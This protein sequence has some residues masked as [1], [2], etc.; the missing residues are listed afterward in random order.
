MC[1]DFR[2]RA[3]ELDRTVRRFSIGAKKG[4]L[5]VEGDAAPLGTW[6]YPLAG[7]WGFAM[8][9]VF[10]Q[11]IRLCYRVEARSEGLKNRSGV[12]RNAMVFHVL[13]NRGVSTDAETQAIRRRM[14]RLLLVNLGGFVLLWIG[15]RASGATG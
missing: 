15:L 14:I 2:Q 1:N 3:A 11:A 9:A 12:P 6:L 7:V 10:I 4:G 13:A 8:L 5:R